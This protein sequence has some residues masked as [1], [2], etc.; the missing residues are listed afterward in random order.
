MRMITKDYLNGKPGIATHAI[1][2]NNQLQS[3]MDYT[4]LKTHIGSKTTAP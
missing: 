2:S 1:N 3:A 4:K